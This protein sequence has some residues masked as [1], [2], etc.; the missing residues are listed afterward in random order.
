LSV[1]GAAPTVLRAGFSCSR[2]SSVFLALQ[3]HRFLTAGGEVRLN[4]RKLRALEI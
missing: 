4:L 3:L 1:S 2:S